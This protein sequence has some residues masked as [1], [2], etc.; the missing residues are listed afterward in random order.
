MNLSLK[1]DTWKTYFEA[2][3]TQQNR[4]QLKNLR[5]SNLR[6]TKTGK[7]LIKKL[8]KSLI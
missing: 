3:N 8:I 6:L 2:S 5:H 7:T 4:T 1:G